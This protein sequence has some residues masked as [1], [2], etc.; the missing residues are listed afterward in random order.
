MDL[1]TRIDIAAGRQPADL[2]LRNGK[3]VNVLSCEIHAGDVAIVGAAINLAHNLGL[4]VIADG[5]NAA[6]EAPF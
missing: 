4:Q 5:L 1:R 3:I 2:V 6:K